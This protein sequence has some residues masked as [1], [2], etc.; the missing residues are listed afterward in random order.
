MCHNRFEKMHKIIPVPCFRVNPQ[1]DHSREDGR[2]R[3]EEGGP[4]RLAEGAHFF[5]V[6]IIHAGI[7]SDHEIIFS[8]GW[9]RLGEDG[10]W[11][12]DG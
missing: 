9:L 11:I 6:E 2:H 8:V 10:E 3:D 7:F 12:G 1:N 5:I 4:S